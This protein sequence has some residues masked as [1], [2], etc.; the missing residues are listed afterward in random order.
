MLD[1]LTATV[2]RLTF[3]AV[4]PLELPRY[5]GSTFR[6]AL[7]HAFRHVCCPIRCKDSGTCLLRYKC[8][9][10]VCFETPVPQDAAIMRKYPFAPHPF[11][12]EP[13]DDTRTHYE[14]GETFT[15][16]LC[17]VGRA[18][19][20]LPHFIYAFEEIGQ[21]G[22]GR[23][24]G[25]AELLRIEGQGLEPSPI[26]QAGD[27]KLQGTAPVING[28]FVTR[29][30]E[31]LQ[32][33]PLRLL[34]ETPTRIKVNG[35]LSQEPHL[36][37]IMPA[38]LRRLTSLHYFHCN[39]PSEYE[40]RPLLDAAR[41]VTTRAMDGHWGD[42][43]RYSNRQDVT[44]KLG[45]FIGTVEYTQIPADLLPYLVWGEIVHLGKASAF[46]LGKYSL[47]R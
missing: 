34:F 31:E 24:R 40:V 9:Y 13:P 46:G 2:Q 1:H 42:W 12:L 26:Y 8:A 35:T 32:E 6:G 3:R 15:L 5:K 28:A 27:D 16:N 47:T 41:D 45:G 29:R 23:G 20:Y 36:S 18:N 30:V 44:M 37:N 19:E 4:D 21:R 11:V 22:L 39:G 17:L 7:G 38:L 33:K 10:S 43:Q 14:P 25:K